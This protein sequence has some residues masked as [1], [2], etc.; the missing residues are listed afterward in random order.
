MDSGG[1]EIL[2][3]STHFQ[4]SNIDWPQQPPTERVLKFH[5]IFHDSTKTKLFSKYQSKAKFKNLDDTKVLSSD[6]PGLKAAATSMT[7]TASTTSVAS[8]TSAAS[9]HQKLYS[10]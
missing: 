5:M 9:F 4:K 6:F 8:M 2:V 1:L 10:V 3:S 7:S